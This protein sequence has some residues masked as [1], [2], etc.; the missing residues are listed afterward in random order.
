MHMLNTDNKKNTVSIT[1]LFCFSLCW[2]CDCC[3]SKVNTAGE[4]RSRKMNKSN[5]CSFERFTTEFSFLAWINRSVRSYLYTFQLMQLIQNT[6]H[7]H[8]RLIRMTNIRCFVW[9]RRE[10]EHFIFGNWRRQT[11][12]GR[13]NEANKPKPIDVSLTHAAN[14]Q[15]IIFRVVMPDSY[16]MTSNISVALV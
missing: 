3:T 8:H 13:S 5:Q 2:C 7:T 11:H 1:L 9:R 10:W 4:W 14:Q 15:T 16:R 6:I 12:T